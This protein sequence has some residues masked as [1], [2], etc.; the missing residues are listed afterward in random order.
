MNDDDGDDE[1]VLPANESQAEEADLDA[2]D[3]DDPAAAPCAA[4][5]SAHTY[6]WKKCSPPQVPDTFDQPFSDPNEK[7]LTAFQYFKMFFS[8]ETID[9]ITNQTNLY[10]TKMTCSSINVSNDEMST[11]ADAMPQIADA[12]PQKRFE[13]I[14]RFLHFVNNDEIDSGDKLAKIRP[15]IDA[16]TQQCRKVEPEEYNAVDEQII[17]SKTK[18]S[19]IRQYN[20]KKPH[21]WGFKNLVRAGASGMRY[22][23]YIYTG[24]ASEEEDTEYNN[25]QKSA[26]VVAKLCRDL[27]TNAGF[28][29]C[30]DNWF[31]TL[32]LMHYLQDRG[33]LAIGT[34]RAN[35]L[36]KCPLA[37][38]KDLEKE[39][40]GS[41]DYR[42]DLNSDI[43]IVKWVDNSTVT[44]VSNYVGIQPESVIQRWC[45]E[46]K[47]RCD[48]PCPRI[49]YVYNK[50]M[51]GVDLADMLISL[52]RIQANT[53]RWYIK[54]FW[55]L[56]DICKVNAW[57][58]Y[59]RHY[60]QMGFPA[61]KRK[62]LMNFSC[63]IAEALIYAD[64][65]PEKP[66]Q[67]R[68]SKRAS[69]ECAPTVGKRPSNPL[70]VADVRYDNIA[71][72]PA[73]THDKKRCRVC[74]A[75]G[76]MTCEKCKVSLCL[77]PDRNCFKKFHTEA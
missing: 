6:C 53:K 19:K 39:G 68:P 67:G 65:G 49:V 37:S 54:I 60:E 50:K 52:Y 4:K 30:F 34:I 61:R 72:W 20:P 14:R 8:D 1:D 27:P 10:S 43:V 55:H 36:Q 62:S 25:L 47:E 58:L 35:R 2:E 31:S 11:F 70:P 63:E 66:T 75:Y 48:V 56:V 38:N 41:S 22:D 28:K 51:G 64:K 3:N 44:V 45:R 16:V 17:P 59:R 46:K 15:I 26:Q 21:K 12:M 13:K 9:L 69:L 40:R 77:L 24:K 42:V 73:P 33:I 18:F 23:F 5:K 71:H 74:H 57:L 76:R 7:E 32:D 29:V